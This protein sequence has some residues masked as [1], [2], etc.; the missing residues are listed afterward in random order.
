MTGSGWVTAPGLL[1]TLQR[2]VQCHVLSCGS[3]LGGKELLRGR[4]FS[5]SVTEHVRLA[6]EEIKA[7]FSSR[8]CRQEDLTHASYA[9][10]VER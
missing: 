10:A 2:D 7:S 9:L 4:Y 8:P 6:G 5:S 1:L 3:A